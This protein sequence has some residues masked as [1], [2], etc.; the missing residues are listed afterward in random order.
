VSP[1][2]VIGAALLLAAT[3]TPVAQADAAKTAVATFAGGCFWC[4]EADFEKMPGVL[5]AVSGYTGGDE[6]N[7][8]YKQVSAGGTGHVEAVEVR[9]DPAKVTYAQLLDVFWRNVDPLDAGGQFCDRGDQYRRS[10]A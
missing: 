9:Y 1:R 6:A 7:P 10:P 5:E 8:T 2:P 4:T 3:A